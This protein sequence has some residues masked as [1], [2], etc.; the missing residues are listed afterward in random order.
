MG[1][2]IRKSVSLG[3]VRFNLSKSG[4]GMSTGMRGL[5]WGTGPRGNY[6]HM[7]RHGLYFRQSLTPAPSGGTRSTPTETPLV[8]PPST[9]GEFQEIDSGDVLQMQDSSSASLLQELNEKRGRTRHTVWVLIVGGLLTLVIGPLGLLITAFGTWLAWI[10]DRTRRTTVVLYDL[11]PEVAET[12]SRLHTAFDE[13]Q[14]CGG[15]WH[16]S[17]KAG[18]RDGKYHAGAGALIKRQAVSLKAGQPP[19]MKVNFDVPLLPVGRQTLAFF[20]DRLLV[21][22]T[23]GVGAVNYT[24]L[25]VESAESRFIERDSVPADATIVDHTWSYVNK[26]GGPDK[27]FKDN[28]ELPVCAYTAVAFTSESG[29]N[30]L[31]QLSK[32]TAGGPLLEALDS[33]RRLAVDERR[34][35]TEAAD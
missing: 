21:F 26:K 28:R 14:G 24:D 10:S 3:P 4:V 9:V 32:R 35:L 11:E 29:L 27:R 34:H 2:H 31:L 7:G 5:R 15:K 12:Y 33:M 6:V 1:F 23:R 22:D 19:L 25:T 18:V 20:P 16:V 8:I 30:E 17:A 13:L